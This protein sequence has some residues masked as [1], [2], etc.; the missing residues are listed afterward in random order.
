MLRQ[1]LWKHLSNIDMTK[2]Q[3]RSPCEID[4][5][6]SGG[7]FLGYYL[8]GMDRILRKLNKTGRICIHRYAG[9]S[10]GALASVA[11]VCEIGDHMISLYDHLQGHSDYFSRIKHYFL[12]IL[13]EDAYLQ[14]SGRVYISITRIKFLYGILP[15]FVPMVVSSFTSNEDLVDACMASSNVPFLVSPSLFYPFRGFWCLDGCF[16]QNVCLFHDNKR[17]QVVVHLYKIPYS[18][19]SIFTPFYNL[20]IPLIVKGAI[21]TE[22][23]LLE[24]NYHTTQ[25]LEWVIHYPRTP[26]KYQFKR[27]L[28]L[29]TFVCGSVLVLKKRFL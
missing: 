20:A 29:T 25:A 16:T 3:E 18:W 23:F 12:S 26:K 27:W 24:E 2:L 1:V 7:G 19:R 21:E 6:I 10:V 17:P 9:T 22:A 14:C 13:P 28:I 11:M 5:V 8:V 15:V 4:I